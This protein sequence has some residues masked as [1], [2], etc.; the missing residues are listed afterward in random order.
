LIQSGQ[1]S[2]TRSVVLIHKV[3]TTASLKINFAV[4][5]TQIR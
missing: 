2:P 3:S 1:L 5:S 4:S